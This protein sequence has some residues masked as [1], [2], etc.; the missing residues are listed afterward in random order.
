MTESADLAVDG[1]VMVSAEGRQQASLYVKDGRIM[2]IG[3]AGL[4][5]R[6]RV[7]ASGLLA[8]PGFVDTHVHLMEPAS[9]D[10][11]DWAHGTRAA[12]ASGVTTIIEHTHAQPVRTKADLR[13]KRDYILS[14]SLVD[15]A[16]AAHAWPTEVAVLG[17]LWSAG[18]AF[19]KVFTCTT[20][21]IPGFGAGPLEETLGHLSRLHAIALVH[22]EDEATTKLAA[23]RL[24]AEGREDGGIIPEWRSRE[25]EIL[26]VRQVLRLTHSSGARVVI[27]HASHRA[28]VDLVAEAR[29]AGLA[30]AVESC[31]Q[32][33]LLREDEVRTLGGFRKFTPP[34]RA[35][36]E[37]DF[38][39]MWRA[40]GPTRQIDLLSSD[41]APATRTQKTAA[42]IWDVH[43]GLP[44]LDTTSAVLVDA[45]LRGKLSLERVVELYATAPARTYGLRSKGKLM[46]GADAD[47][48]LLDA[49]AERTLGDAPIYSKAGWTPYQGM[50]VRGRVVS[51]YVRGVPVFVNGEFPTGFGH[52]KFVAGMGLGSSTN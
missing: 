13:S 47:F 43:F 18:V 39:D 42:G 52:G 48:A 10:R 33:F 20:H 27:A 44:G 2:H 30:V 34:A 16:L 8:L 26:A 45:A 3:E 6:H 24:R 11:E 28:V 50:A 15:F 32:Y 31:P 19:F 41:H 36:S 22:C 46:V 35:R 4:A 14:R 38:D 1:A 17:D 37:A 40:L 29:G 21:G 25:A 9:P 5:S 51:T 49:A 7:D 23:H 12:A